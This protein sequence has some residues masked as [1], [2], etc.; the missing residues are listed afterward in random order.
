MKKVLAAVAVAIAAVFAVPTAAAAVE[1]GYED[2]P[3]VGNGGS[4]TVSAGSRA[5]VVLNGGWAPGSPVTITIPGD[6]TFVATTTVTA[7]ADGTAAFAARFGTPG[8]Y[9][10]T[11]TGGFTFSITAV[12]AP[13]DGGMPVTGVDATPYLWLGGGLAAVGIA[14]VVTFIAV[15]RQASAK[16]DA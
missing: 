5:E 11:A 15:R 9:S 16:V 6:V 2:A 10:G 4:A 1:P 8:T 14:L 12:A 7:A 13:T 3:V